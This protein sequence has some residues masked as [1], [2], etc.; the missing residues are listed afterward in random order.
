MLCSKS[1]LD[2]PISIHNG[3]RHLV[4]WGAAVWALVSGLVSLILSLSGWNIDRLWLYLTAGAMLV[5]MGMQ[6]VIFW[7]I[8]RVLDELNQRE[9]LIRADMEREYIC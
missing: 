5:L 3:N 6:L 8:M 1:L 2:A 7:V 4:E 9:R